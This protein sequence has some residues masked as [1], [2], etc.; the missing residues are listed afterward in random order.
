MEEIADVIA[1]IGTDYTVSYMTHA[2]QKWVY[3]AT[4][5]DNDLVVKFVAVEEFDP[6]GD[7]TPL[8]GQEERLRREL[9]LMKS[10]TSDYLPQLGP[11][12]LTE[13]T[14]DGLRY[15]YF[16]EKYI[17]D[18]NV[19]DLIKDGAFSPSLVR[20]LICDVANALMAYSGFENGFVHR[21]IKP[22]NIVMNDTSNKFILIDGGV[23]MLPSNP[24]MTMSDAFVG[25]LR[26]AAPEQ[27]LNGRRSLDPRSDIFCL[28]IVLYEAA[29]GR[30]PFF[31]KGVDPQACLQNLTLA[32]YAPI[33]DG[34]YAAFNVLLKKMLTQ[35]QHSRYSGPEDLLKEIEELQV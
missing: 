5:S 18:N 2:G 22:A 17:G 32:K 7:I 14:H 9:R 3:R 27:I 12:E 31:V 35:Y 11:I 29:T 26:Y 19:K 30:H 6:D 15:L 24:T 34:P 16:S 20:Q 4:S 25:T 33:E 10:V 1:L 8:S 13:Y 21:D 28:G 23:H